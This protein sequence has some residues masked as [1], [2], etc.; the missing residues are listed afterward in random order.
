MWIHCDETLINFLSTLSSDESREKLITLALE[1]D[2][3]IRRDSS[4]LETLKS[5]K[6]KVNLIE[7][8][9]RIFL[10]YN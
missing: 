6:S 2:I 5:F 9:P 7:K 10:I 1:R 3:E 4:I 8:Y